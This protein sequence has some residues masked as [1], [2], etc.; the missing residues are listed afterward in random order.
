MKQ[1]P[2]HVYKDGGHFQRQGGTYSAAYVTTQ[3]DL[4]AKIAAGW[5]LR[6]ADIGK[7]KE[8][9]APDIKAPE[10]DDAPTLDELKIKARELGLK[11]GP[12][13]KAETLTKLIADKLNE[14]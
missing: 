11:F 6:I 9:A 5:G 10:S 2:T 1:L 3:E 13:T 8:V 4:E 12:N 14:A 7:P